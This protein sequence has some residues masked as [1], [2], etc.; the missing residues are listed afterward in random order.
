MAV[1][2]RKNRKGKKIEIKN[3][4]LISNLKPRVEY[5]NLIVK[6]LIAPACCEKDYKLLEQ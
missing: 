1:L 5:I 3:L 2:P 4:L 6:I